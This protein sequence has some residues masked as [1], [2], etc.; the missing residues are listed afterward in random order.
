MN[1]STFRSAFIRQ[2]LATVAL[3]LIPSAFAA[4]RNST[5]RGNWSATIWSCGG[6]P[7][8]PL[9]CAAA[10]TVNRVE[11]MSLGLPL[12]GQSLGGML[13]AVG[14][15]ELAPNT[16]AATFYCRDPGGQPP[17]AAG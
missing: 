12:G 1:Q 4:T 6:G 8:P 17:R 11:N 10:P 15:A 13:L 16:D 14:L 9:V 7:T 5:G 3:G 2:L